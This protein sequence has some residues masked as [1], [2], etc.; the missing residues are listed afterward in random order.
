MAVPEASFS[1]IER[2]ISEK[3][4]APV[5]FL[6][7]DEPYFIDRLVEKF[8]NELLPPD[9][10]DFN[11]LIL[12]GKDVDAPTVITTARRAP[13]MSDRLLVILKEAQQMRRPDGLADYVKKPA[14][15]TTLVI[16]Y[17]TD[18]N[19][20]L[21]RR[22]AFFKAFKKHA[23]LFE[24]K[25]LK[26]WEARKWVKQYVADKGIRISDEAVAVTLDYLGPH[27][28]LITQ[29]LDRIAELNDGKPIE[30]ADVHEQMGEHREF[31]IYELLRA[32]SEAA[33]DRALHIAEQISRSKT[34]QH[35]LPFYL[36]TLYQHY[37]R[38]RL[39]Q[40]APH[41]WKELGI[42]DWARDQYTALSRRYGTVHL[43]RILTVLH[44]CERIAKGMEGLR[45][46]AENLFLEC[47]TRIVNGE[48]LIK[49]A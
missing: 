31:N 21:D 8:E 33:D 38:A 25:R 12:Y 23:V 17:K 18:D 28:K 2:Q 29:Y 35:L 43:D 39:V 4:P 34:I 26:V 49:E 13:M 27:L 45:E 14:P 1:D 24:S 9:Q 5:Y 30:A 42:P 10:W 20:R 6:F 7:G 19:K 48:V 16:A 32:L 44:H 22:T 15:T 3:S 37:A 40:A 47:V 11:R 36:S 41:A 46:R